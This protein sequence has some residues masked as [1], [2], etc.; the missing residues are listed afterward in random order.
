[1]SSLG[2]SGTGLSGTKN[3]L[4][5]RVPQDRWR[6]QD[7]I[8]QGGNSMVLLYSFELPVPRKV[9]HV[10]LKGVKIAG[11]LKLKSAQLNAL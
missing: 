7:S 3:E 11:F 4:E 2:L 10:W 5:H 9:Q 1:M 8:F 6:F